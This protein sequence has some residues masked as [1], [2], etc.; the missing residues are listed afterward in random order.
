M[1]HHLYRRLL[2]PFQD[3]KFDPV[4]DLVSTMPSQ[5]VEKYDF[6]RDVVRG[7]V[8]ASEAPQSKYD[9]VWQ[10]LQSAKDADDQVRKG[11]D[12]DDEE[13]GGNGSG[14]MG[15]GGGNGRA[16]NGGGAVEAGAAVQEVAQVGGGGM[17]CRS[18]GGWFV[19]HSSAGAGTGTACCFVQTLRSA[20]PRALGQRWSLA[21]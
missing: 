13:E 14:G 6:L 9:M 17:S 16:S 2:S 10:L 1:E 5:G 21:H 20:Q 7:M 11:R 15:G 4:R 18:L 12:D 8:A 19:R 3:S